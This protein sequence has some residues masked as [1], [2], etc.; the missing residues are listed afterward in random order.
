L[1]INSSGYQWTPSIAGVVNP[2]Y[3]AGAV[4]E[5]F[6][7]A[8]F[9]Y[10]PET[11]KPGP[12]TGFV[13]PFYSGQ[14]INDPST[15]EYLMFVDLDVGNDN[16]RN[17]IDS[18][19]AKVDFDVSGIYDTTVAFNAYAWAF[20]ANIADSSINWTNDLSTNP[21]AGGQSGF[22]INTTA[23][24]VPEPGMLFPVGLAMIFLA[25]RGRQARQY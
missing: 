10:G 4:N 12:G 16:L 23:M 20:S 13:L 2:V 24:P 7:G 11:A 9:L 17:S 3:K 14:N 1:T 8:D 19:D 21:A 15:A 6:T 18:G 5:T 22:S 25:R